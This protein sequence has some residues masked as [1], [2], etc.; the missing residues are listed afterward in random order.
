[1]TKDQLHNELEKLIY[2]CYMVVY[3]QNSEVFYSRD[4]NYV[5]V[6]KCDDVQHIDEA[7]FLVRQASRGDFD[8]INVIAV[9]YDEIGDTYVETKI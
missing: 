1:M 5:A 7:K 4:D 8:E 3:R 9:H 6:M 2:P